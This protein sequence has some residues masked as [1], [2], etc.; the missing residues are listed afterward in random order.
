MLL[1]AEHSLFDQSLLFCFFT[2]NYL[3]VYLSYH[4][5]PTVCGNC[6]FVLIIPNR[7]QIPH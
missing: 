5:S 2:L 3:Q 4:L 6:A 7:D 1:L